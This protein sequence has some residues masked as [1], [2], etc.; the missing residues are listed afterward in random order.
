EDPRRLILADRWGNRYK[1][2]RYHLER[3]YEVLKDFPP[4]REIAVSV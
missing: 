4:E 2:R 1:I 3:G